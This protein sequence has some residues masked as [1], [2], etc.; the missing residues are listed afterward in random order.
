MNT[1][2]SQ[3]HCS[4]YKVKKIISTKLKHNLNL[5]KIQ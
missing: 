5:E 1:E 2:E 4:K 3:A